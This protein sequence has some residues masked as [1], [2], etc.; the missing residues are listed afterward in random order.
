MS[1][2]KKLFKLPENLPETIDRRQFN[3]EHFTEMQFLEN[4]I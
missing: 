3:E 1:E 4:N 2:S